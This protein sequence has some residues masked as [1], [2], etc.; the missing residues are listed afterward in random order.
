VAEAVADRQ[1]VAGDPRPPV[2][3]YAT[4]DLVVRRGDLPTGRMLPGRLEAAL[5]ARNLFDA[6][7][8]EPS[9]YVPGPLPRYIP[10]DLPLAGRSIL[11]ELRWRR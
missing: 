4:V 3:D 9:F 7:V 8:L 10:G 6:T 2:D 1:R 11:V 5:L